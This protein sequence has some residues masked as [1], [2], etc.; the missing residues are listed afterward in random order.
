MPKVFVR[1][2]KCTTFSFE[3]KLAQPTLRPIDS[4]VDSGLIKTIDR[5]DSGERKAP[6]ANVWRYC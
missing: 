3:V 5:S 4:E 1:N 2:D 6:E